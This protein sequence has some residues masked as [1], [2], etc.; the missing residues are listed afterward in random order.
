MQ[1]GAPQT[2]ADPQVYT[3]PATSMALNSNMMWVAPL[4]HIGGTPYVQDGMVSVHRPLLP[5]YVQDG[6]AVACGK[7]SVRDVVHAEPPLHGVVVVGSDA[8]A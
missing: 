1:N 5:G 8:M 6:M 3:S 4:L 2:P 7:C